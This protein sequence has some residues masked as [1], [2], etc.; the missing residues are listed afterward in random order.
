MKAL[1]GVSVILSDEIGLAVVLE[2]DTCL[3]QEE[4]TANLG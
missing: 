1:I 3:K 4:A 2:A